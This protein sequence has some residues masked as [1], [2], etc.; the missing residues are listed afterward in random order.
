MYREK[1]LKLSNDN[2]TKSTNELEQNQESVLLEKSEKVRNLEPLN[3][4][5]K[6]EIILILAGLK[7][8]TVISIYGDKESAQ[9]LAKKIEE[10]GLI[11][12]E[13]ENSP[14]EKIKKETYKFAVS[15][16]REKAEQLLSLEPSR[17][18]DHKRF[19]LLMGFPPTAVDAFVE[20]SSILNL[21]EEKK[22]TEKLLPIFKF[23]F[24]T[25][26]SKEELKVLE[27]WN[28]T[29]FKCAP[30]LIEDMLVN[31]EDVERYKNYLS[32]LH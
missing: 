5:A 3:I 26:N 21:E 9:S 29:I 8:A 11:V 25:K 1:E 17:D 6:G 23:K 10:L 30:W 7:P 32:T 27:K 19:G 28:S 2:E 24:S 20:K 31:D 16:S 4:I 22:L 13:K 12:I 14:K 18:E 15:L